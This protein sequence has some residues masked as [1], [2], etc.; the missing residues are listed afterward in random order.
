MADGWKKMLL[1]HLNQEIIQ[2]RKCPRLVQF[3]E[4][5]I[6]R[7]CYQHETY[8]KKP[9][10]G[11]GDP[12]AW[13]L[14]TGL[15]PAAHGGNRTGRILTGDKTSQ[16]F[17][18]CLYQTGFAN[19]PTSE[20]INDGLI[21]NGC[22]ITAAVKC[23][24]P[25]DKPTRQEAINCNPYYQQELELLPNVTHILALGRFAFE[26]ILMTAKIKGEAVK[27][28]TF[29]HGKKYSF[30]HFPTVHAMYHPSPQNTQTGKLT[31]TMTLEALNEIKKQ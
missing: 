19:Q 21:L 12:N 15:A 29:S 26:C 20:Y 25:K 30:S 6:P 23:V 24:P 27:G 2:C 13:L 9:V 31:E 17:F 4:N 3:R 10:P 14:I 28:L 1:S 22:Y 5:V 16:F 18:K 11:F 7:P 8:W